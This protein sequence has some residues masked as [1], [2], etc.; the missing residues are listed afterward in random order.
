MRNVQKERGAVLPSGQRHGAGVAVDG[1]GLLLGC[2][3][4]SKIA[5]GDSCVSLRM[6]P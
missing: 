1:V 6:E 5:G 3:Q 2:G 4:R